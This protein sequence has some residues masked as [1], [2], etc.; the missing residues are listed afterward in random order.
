M[1]NN[2]K[3]LQQWMD[4]IQRCGTWMKEPPDKFENLTEVG[5]WMDDDKEVRRPTR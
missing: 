3:E 4:S 5:Q 2:I 1:G